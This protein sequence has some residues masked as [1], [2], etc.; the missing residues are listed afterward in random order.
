MK[1]SIKNYLQENLKYVEREIYNGAVIK[2]TPETLA[3]FP[4]L[5]YD[6]A[7]DNE[8]QMLLNGI[9]YY[10]F[11]EESDLIELKKDANYYTDEI[12]Y[13]LIPTEYIDNENVKEEA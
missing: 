2:I 11:G 13:V 10:W 5:E 12:M 3:L 8:M 1:Q 6:S 7:E 4:Y 9:K